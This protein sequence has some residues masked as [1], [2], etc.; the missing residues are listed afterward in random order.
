MPPTAGGPTAGAGWPHKESDT[1]APQKLE[2]VERDCLLPRFSC[3]LTPGIPAKGCE[4]LVAFAPMAISIDSSTNDGTACRARAIAQE[5][6]AG[7]GAGGKARAA[8]GAERHT[9]RSTSL[10]LVLSFASFSILLPFPSL[11]F[12]SSLSLSLCVCVCVLC[13]RA[14]THDTTQSVARRADATTSPGQ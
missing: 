14:A 10:L 7:G 4:A 5:G 11:S 3:G 13:P 2:E 6:E 9:P 1:T 8:E 12:Y